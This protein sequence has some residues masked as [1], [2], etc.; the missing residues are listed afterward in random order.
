MSY[1][2][3]RKI[4]WLGFWLIAA[5]LSFGCGTYSV[6]TNII[7]EPNSPARV[8][9][10]MVFALDRRVFDALSES[11]LTSMDEAVESLQEKGWQASSLEGGR[12]LNGVR[13]PLPIDRLST[14]GWQV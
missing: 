9:M 8:G 7:R 12:V 10:D 2:N 1:A 11:N 13:P 3:M 4:K 5:L 6:A 14:G